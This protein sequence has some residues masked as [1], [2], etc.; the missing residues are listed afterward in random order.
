MTLKKI[1]EKLSS[2]ILKQ[3][4]KSPSRRATKFNYT[5][6]QGYYS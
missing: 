5:K 6:T 3:L 1:P 4:K 2:K